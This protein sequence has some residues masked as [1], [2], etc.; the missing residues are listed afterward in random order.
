MATTILT[1]CSIIIAYG[2]GFFSG[3]IAMAKDN[4][5]KNNEER[6]KSPIHFNQIN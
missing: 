2:F 5:K 6:K 4:A 3:T 1:V